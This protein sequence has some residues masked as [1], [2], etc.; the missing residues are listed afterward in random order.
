MNDEDGINH[1]KIYLIFCSYII[2]LVLVIVYLF[3]EYFFK[4]NHLTPTLKVNLNK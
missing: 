2:Y 3:G 1:K 4:L